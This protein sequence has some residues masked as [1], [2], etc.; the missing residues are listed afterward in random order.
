MKAK[1]YFVNTELGHPYSEPAGA[2]RVQVSKIGADYSSNHPH[3][4]RPVKAI[5]GS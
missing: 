1:V 4:S 2:L 5:A 3:S